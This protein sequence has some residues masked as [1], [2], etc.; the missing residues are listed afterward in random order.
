MGR[1]PPKGKGQEGSGEGD[2]DSR[3]AGGSHVA[4]VSHRFRRGHGIGDR[5]YDLWVDV[6]TARDRLC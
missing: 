1:V 6:F 2:A 5:Q 4:S 3:V